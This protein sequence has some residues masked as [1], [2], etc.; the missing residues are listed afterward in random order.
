MKKLYHKIQSLFRR[1]PVVRDF[2][3]MKAGRNEIIFYSVRYSSQY[4]DCPQMKFEKGLN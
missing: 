1:K 2:I 4:F 3:F